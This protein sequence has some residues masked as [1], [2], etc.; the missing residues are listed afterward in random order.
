[1]GGVA[2][3]AECL[4]AVVR[5]N[6]S[7]PG[8]GGDRRIIE[9]S[10]GEPFDEVLRFHV[11]ALEVEVEVAAVVS[12]DGD[13]TRTSAGTVDTVAVQVG[14]GDGINTGE[15]DGDTVVAVPVVAASPERAAAHASKPRF[16]ATLALA[17]CDCLAALA[18]RSTDQSLCRAA[19]LAKVAESIIALPIFALSV[20][21]RLPLA[22]T[23][24][25]PTNLGVPLPDVTATGLPSIA[26]KLVPE[27]LR[28][29]DDRMVAAVAD[30]RRRALSGAIGLMDC[31]MPSL[32]V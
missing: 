12:T 6:S 24:R 10:N 27:L 9:R 8:G 3:K 1:M 23:N 32:L 7:K 25:R 20:G 5:C 2:G 22:I 18:T 26:T 14:A 17:R 21:R 30:S 28:L 29:V 4:V 19:T 11:P 31:V 15:D 16:A 13:G